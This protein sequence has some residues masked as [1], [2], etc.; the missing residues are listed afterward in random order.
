MPVAIV[1]ERTPGAV[2]AMVSLRRFPP[3]GSIDAQN[4]ARFITKNSDGQA[5]ARTQ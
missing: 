2:S 4:D 3:P 5:F 1:P